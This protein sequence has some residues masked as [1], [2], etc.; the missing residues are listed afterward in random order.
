MHFYGAY[1]YT[2]GVLRQ[3]YFT[4]NIITWE[5]NKIN[6]N[7]NTL[8]WAPI[9]LCSAGT[10]SWMDL[11]LMHGSSPPPLNS[12]PLQLGTSKEYSFWN[13]EEW[14]KQ[15]NRVKLIGPKY[16]HHFHAFSVL[17]QAWSKDGMLLHLPGA[18]PRIQLFLSPLS[19]AIHLLQCDLHYVAL[20]Y[21]SVILHENLNSVRKEFLSYS[22]L[23]SSTFQ[24]YLAQE[25]IW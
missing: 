14:Q 17:L 7:A 19:L 20:R 21:F 1:S 24:E 10:Q 6:P 22:S 25:R 18:Q 8:A 12:A 5:R 13:G 3:R 15:V 4:I 23:R 9:T 2:A 16:R 11:L